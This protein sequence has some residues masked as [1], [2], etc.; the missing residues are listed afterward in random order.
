ML[1]TRFQL[2]PRSRISGIIHLF[3]HVSTLLVQVQI[4]PSLL[5][6][7]SRLVSACCLCCP[8]F[9][10]LNNFTAFHKMWIDC[11]AIVY[12]TFYWCGEFA[13]LLNLSLFGCSN[14]NQHEWVRKFFILVETHL[15][16]YPSIQTNILILLLHCV[17]SILRKKNV[18]G[19]DL[20]N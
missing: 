14:S 15:W 5:R 6:K 4:Y 10:L 3:P 18:V 9:Q 2:V 17:Y 12:W 20:K 16:W 11:Y 8:H 7:G 13:R 19:M 1:T